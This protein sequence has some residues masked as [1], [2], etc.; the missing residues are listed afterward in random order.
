MKKLSNIFSFLIVFILG[1]TLALLPLRVLYWFSD[2]LYYLNY[3][4]IGYRKKVVFKN[5]AIAFPEKSEA[6]YIEISKKFYR[7]FCDVI[8]ETLKMFHLSSRELKRRVVLNNPEVMDDYYRQNKHVLL[9]MGHYN[10]WEWGI[11]IGL[12]MKYFSAAIYKPLHNVL[13]DKLMNRLRTQYG[14]EMVPM[15]QTARFLVD[16]IRKKNLTCISFISDQSPLKSE[17][18]YWADF[19]N[20]KTAVYLGIEKLAI[21][22]RQPVFFMHINKVRRG[23]YSVDLT[24]ICDDASLLAPYQLTDMHTKML[25]DRIREKPEFWLWTHRRWKLKK[26]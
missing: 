20:Q 4:V 19:F 12:Q 8:F 2:G 18:Q 24:K 22:T 9:V 6:E 1:K 3:Y 26:D 16:N 14:S 21:K 17:T 5:L 11:G 10:N 15:H 7:H 13:F 23:Y 25:E